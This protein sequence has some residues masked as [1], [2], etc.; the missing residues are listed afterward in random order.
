MPSRSPLA[1]VNPAALRWARESLGFTLEDAAKRLHL[2][3]RLLWLAEEGEDHLTMR[4]AEA[5]ARLYERPVAALFLPD[6]PQEESP[7]AQFRRLPGAPEPPW[8]PEMRSLARRVQ[9]R[10]DEAVEL[11][12]I[13]DEQPAWPRADIPLRDDPS[14]VAAHVRELV[15]LD[16]DEQRSWRDTSGYTP[17]RAWVDAVESLG[18]MVIQDGTLP[19]DL[20]RGFAAKHDTVPAVVVNTQDDARARAFTVMHELG[21]LILGNAGR[22]NS[23][24]EMW[25]NDFAGAVIAPPTDFAADFR[26]ARRASFVETI[27]EVALRYGITP[28]AA[29]VRV[30]RLRLASQD[31]VDQAIEEIRH[32]PYRQKGDGGNYYRTMIGRLSPSF[33]DLVFTALDSQAISYPAAS[34]LLGVKVNNFETLRTYLDERTRS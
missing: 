5:A 9:E 33:I 17:M 6:P 15:D 20:M 18:V 27:D 25:C 13:L 28:M 4:Q 8:P 30:A 12:D 19:I 32:R 11:L 14:E 10:Q 7:E 22:P 2:K 3:P 26:N 21:H 24:T 1:Q 34:G 16:L 23:A 31:D 29:A